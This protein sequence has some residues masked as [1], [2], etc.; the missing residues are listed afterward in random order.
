MSGLPWSFVNRWRQLGTMTGLSWDARSCIRVGGVSMMSA[1][2]QRTHDVDGPMV[3]NS[4]EL[5]AL[6]IAA[7]R[8]F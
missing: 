7:R 6:D 5:R 8:A 4:R 1:S 2:S 3:V